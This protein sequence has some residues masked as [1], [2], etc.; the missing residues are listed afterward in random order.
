MDTS[1]Q[2]LLH[3]FSL[4][5][6][7][8]LSLHFVRCI[9]VYILWADENL[10]SKILQPLHDSNNFS[11]SV[12]SRHHSFRITVA[13]LLPTVTLA[14]LVIGF[15]FVLVCTATDHPTYPC[16][17]YPK[18]MCA[19]YAALSNYC[20]VL[21]GACDTTTASPGPTAAPCTDRPSES[22]RCSQADVSQCQRMP[23]WY[24][25]NCPKTCHN[26]QGQFFLYFSTSVCLWSGVVARSWLMSDESD[27]HMLIG[28]FH[29][30]HP[31]HCCLFHDFFEQ[32]IRLAYNV[33]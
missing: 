26:C 23:G 5:G 31:D 25:R 15:R 13:K 3:I 21:C 22:V 1:I 9:R 33:V 32:G 6:S 8:Y 18:S 14:P 28:S 7:S 29:L 4:H 20:P 12:H 10:L 17:N 11:R 30:C 27:R 24:N 2:H 19:T 16:A